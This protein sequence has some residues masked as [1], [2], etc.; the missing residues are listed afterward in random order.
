MTAEPLPQ[1]SGPPRLLTMAGYAALG[2]PRSGF[3]ELV[4][5]RLVASPSR[6]RDTTRCSSGRRSR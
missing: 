5:G 1:P 3:F 4:E 2:E 6:H